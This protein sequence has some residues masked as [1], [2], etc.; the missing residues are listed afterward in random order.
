MRCDIE[1]VRLFKSNQLITANLRVIGQLVCDPRRRSNT[2]DTD[3]H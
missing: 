3:Q 2:N 1:I